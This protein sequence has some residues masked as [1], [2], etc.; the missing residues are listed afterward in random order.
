MDVGSVGS[1]NRWALNRTVYQPGRR[2]GHYESFYQRANDPEAAWVRAPMYEHVPALAC[3]Y[4]SYWSD[5]PVDGMEITMK[6]RRATFVFPTNDYL[7][8]VFVAFPIDEFAWV[9][10]Q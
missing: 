6:A 5:V 4:F 7:T 10:R 8:A 1:G 2:A 9:R 3:W